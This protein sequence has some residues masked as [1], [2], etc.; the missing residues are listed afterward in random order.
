MRVCHEM[1]TDV[2]AAAEGEEDVPLANDSFADK[3]LDGERQPTLKG[4]SVRN[5]QSCEFTST[6]RPLESPTVNALRHYYMSMDRF[7]NVR[8]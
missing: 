3:H 1:R 5:D 2:W 4:A 6:V 7:N 8:H